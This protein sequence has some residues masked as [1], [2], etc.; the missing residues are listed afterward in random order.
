MQIN[1]FLI[2]VLGSATLTAAACFPGGR[3]SNYNLDGGP[4]LDFAC[5][6]LI[7]TFEKN[8]KNTKTICYMDDLRTRWD[9]ELSYIGTDADR[10]IDL[11]ECVD[12]MAKEASCTYGGRRRYS[13]WEYM[14]DPNDGPCP[15]AFSMNSTRIGVS[16][17]DGDF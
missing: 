6:K 8:G 10:T 3:E 16:E 1:Q 7:G 15:G 4:R 17:Y 5:E 9:F 11:N 13:N 14:A 2:A 12:G